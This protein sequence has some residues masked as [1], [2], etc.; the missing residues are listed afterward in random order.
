MGIWAKV[1][2]EAMTPYTTSKHGVVAMTR[3]MSLGP[4]SNIMHKAI[5]PDTTD[6]DL[7]ADAGKG[8]SPEALEEYKNMC[9][10]WMSPDYVAEVQLVI[11]WSIN[12]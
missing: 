7:V 1:V 9:G 4:R 11:F 8:L 10:G 5:C 2:D 12:H 3:S 6:T